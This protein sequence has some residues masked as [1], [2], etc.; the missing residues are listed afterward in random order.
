MAAKPAFERLLGQ[1][2]AQLHPMH[3]A[4]IDCLMP[5]V[6]CSR[7]VG[8][9]AQAVKHLQQL[10]SA[11]EAVYG[12]HTVEV[13][14]TMRAAC[15]SHAVA[16]LLDSVCGAESGCALQ[17]GNLYGLLGRLYLDRASS[18]SG[19]FQARYKKQVTPAEVP[20]YLCRLA[21]LLLITWAWKECRTAHRC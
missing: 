2:R 20:Q 13:D 3:V 5:L 9:P 4:T 10:L 18:L 8:D 19:A 12:C 1:A 11:L 21:F 14:T 17:I 15:A 16:C 7:A 6:N